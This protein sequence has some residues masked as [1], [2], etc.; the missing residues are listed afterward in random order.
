MTYT[1]AL[2]IFAAM[3]AMIFFR[4]L[5]QKNVMHNNYLA[6]IPTSYLMSALELVAHTMVLGETIINGFTFAAMLY[7][8]AAGTGG[9]TG[10]CAA[11]WFHN[12]YIKGS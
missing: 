9:A 5:Q 1:A 7:W 4:A 10:C 6:V 12:R 3:G 11:M 2:M 8:I